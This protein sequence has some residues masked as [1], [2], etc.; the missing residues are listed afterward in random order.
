MCQLNLA[1]Y[2]VHIEWPLQVNHFLH[3]GAAALKSLSD[4]I[5]GLYVPKAL[6]SLLD[7]AFC[8]P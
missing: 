1:L 4:V 2:L 6:L 8:T 3:D 5:D 7:F